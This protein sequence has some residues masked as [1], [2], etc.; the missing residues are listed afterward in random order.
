[1]T[2]L[3]RGQVIGVPCRVF[4]GAFPHE[5]MVIIETMTGEVSGF[6]RRDEL[7]RIE[8]DH[9]YVR[10]RIVNVSEDTI[11]VLLK[12]SFFTT[13]GLAHF[14]PAWAKSNTELVTA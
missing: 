9:G 6:V 2:H 3:E 10:A 14:S 8:D 7:T 11:S 1:M 5:A 12:G 4:P 13:T